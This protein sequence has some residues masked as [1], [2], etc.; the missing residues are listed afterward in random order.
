[1]EHEENINN[2]YNSK[3]ELLVHIPWDNKFKPLDLDLLESLESLEV[4]EC[5]DELPK[6]TDGYNLLLTNDI[7]SPVN[8][9]FLAGIDYLFWSI[10][11]L[12][13]YILY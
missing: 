13:S 4:R 11:L 8:E 7:F 5:F 3:Y 2:Q 1:M 9:F 10:L 12:L 6:T